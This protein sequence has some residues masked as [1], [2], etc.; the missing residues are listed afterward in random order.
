M[1]NKNKDA[2]Y[3]DE[4]KQAMIKRK[5]IPKNGKVNIG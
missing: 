2:P 1:H 4:D 3:I 5:V